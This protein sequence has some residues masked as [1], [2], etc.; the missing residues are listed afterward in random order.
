MPAII[1]RMGGITPMLRTVVVAQFLV[2]LVLHLGSLREMTRNIADIKRRPLR[3]R[4]NVLRAIVLLL[5]ISYIGYIA[6]LLAEGEERAGIKEDLLVGTAAVLVGLFVYGVADL[7]FQTVKDFHDI[8]RFEKLAHQDQLTGV[9]N[10]RYFDLALEEAVKDAFFYRR[11]LSLIAVDIDHFKSIND[12]YG[13]SSGDTVLRAVCGAIMRQCRHTDIV[14]R[15]GGD[16]LMIIVSGDA[17]IAVTL[18]ER[19]KSMVDNLEVQLATH[20]TLRVTV[21]M[22][23]AK[24]GIDDSPDTLFARADAALYDA[25]RLGRNRI[26][27]DANGYES[28]FPIGRDDGEISE[29]SS[30]GAAANSN[31]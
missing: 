14:A 20:T 13:H 24:I 11:P 6:Q 30:V 29:L 17:A 16:E 31:G 23:I 4:W 21:S 10:R 19:V 8:S 5:A 9:F 7:S 26:E 27:I 1:F 3:F 28:P 15:Y 2:G 22:G 18:A 12:E 25:K